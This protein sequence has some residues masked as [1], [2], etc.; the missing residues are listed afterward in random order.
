MVP[1]EPLERLGQHVAER[2]DV[3][4]LSGSEHEQ[5]KS[6]FLTQAFG[7]R[8][9]GSRF[10]RWTAV[11]FAAALS[12]AALALFIKSSQRSIECFEAGSG[13]PV[14]LGA[15]MSAPNSAALDL[16]FSEGTRAKL[17]PQARGRVTRIDAHGADL[18]VEQGRASFQVVHRDGAHWQVNTGPFVVDVTG[19]R[20]DVEWHPQNDHFELN[21]FEGSVHVSGCAL[22]AGQELR[23]GQRVEASCARKEFRISSLASAT[24]IPHA[25]LRDDAPSLVQRDAA[26]RAQLPAPTEAKTL[27]RSA[28]APTMSASASEQ[29]LTLARAGKFAEAY[30]LA[31]QVGFEAECA[32]RGPTDTLL[33]ADSARLSGHIEAAIQAYQVVRRRWPGSA[34]AAF[35]AFQMGRAEFDQ[36]G[37]YRSA[38]RWLRVYEQEAPNGQF[39]APALGRVM[40][41]ELHLGNVDTARA[42]AR[43]YLDRYP[44]GPHADAANHVLGATPTHAH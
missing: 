20:F 28:N 14:V 23:A 42:L 7:A 2:Q 12:A 24:E 18:V 30:A 25:V 1:L 17:W 3:E 36:R 11:A 27:V 40:E 19:T 26:P 5:Q 9:R 16:R 44:K 38:E 21:L 29:W 8:R 15:W 34:G 41:A 32:N 43:S 33:L 35:A 4:H 10:A 13:L 37:N 39:A 22:G 6:E 31:N